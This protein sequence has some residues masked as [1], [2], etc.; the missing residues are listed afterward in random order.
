VVDGGS[1]GNIPA[2]A[3]P[4]PQFTPAPR[5]EPRV[6]DDDRGSP[7]GQMIRRARKG[8]QEE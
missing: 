8:Q 5:P 4:Q 7:M 2:P 1:G 3:R 6:R